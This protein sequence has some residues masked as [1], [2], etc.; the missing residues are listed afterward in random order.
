MTLLMTSHMILTVTMVKT[1]QVSPAVI[2]DVLLHSDIPA[3]TVWRGL[4]S[5]VIGKFRARL[6]GRTQVI[7]NYNYLSI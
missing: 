6:E 7:S 2:G 1:F 5:P 3:L 4:S